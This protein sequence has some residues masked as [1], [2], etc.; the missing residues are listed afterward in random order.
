MTRSAHTAC[1]ERTAASGPDETTDERETEAE[2]GA[3]AGRSR[4]GRPG[5]R[6]SAAAPRTRAP[7]P[8]RAVRAEAAAEPSAARRAGVAVAA[9]PARP[10]GVADRGAR[11]PGASSRTTWTV[12]PSCPTATAAT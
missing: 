3:A 4:A 8:R 12:D 9:E 7:G 5:G 6:R 10:D 2:Q 1:G 11:R